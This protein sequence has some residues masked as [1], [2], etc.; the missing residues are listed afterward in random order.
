M[1][2]PGLEIQ[3]D[4]EY[5][6]RSNPWRPHLRTHR[7]QTYT[8]THLGAHVSM[9][10]QVSAKSDTLSVPTCSEHQPLGGLDLIV[11]WLQLKLRIS[12]A[13]YVFLRFNQIWTRRITNVLGQFLYQFCGVAAHIVPLGG[14]GD[15]QCHQS[16]P[17]PGG[18]LVSVTEPDISVWHNPP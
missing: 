14:G 15:D 13:Q 16:P 7:T 4:P 1:G 8:V 18:C 12:S 6:R 2:W 3:F 5:Q 9:S 10:W 17:M 11:K